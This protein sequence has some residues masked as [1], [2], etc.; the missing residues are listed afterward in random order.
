[1][2]VTTKLRAVHVHEATFVNNSRDLKEA[3][4]LLRAGLADE[5][6]LVGMLG[7]GLPAEDSP[8][9]GARIERLPRRTRR[10][11]ANKLLALL[12]LAEARWRFVSAISRLRPDVI[13]CHSLGPLA[14]CVS[15][16]HRTGA[17]LIY[18]AHEL[19]TEQVPVK[20][21]RQIVETFQERRL[22]RHCDAVLCV[23]DS[24]ADWYGRAYGIPRPYV[25]RNVPDLRF[26]SLPE[27]SN[28]IRQELG[29]PGESLVFLY[30]GRL[31]PG[32]GVE[33]FI[34][35][36][37]RA[38]PARHIVFMGY[39]PLTDVVMAAAREGGSIHFLPAVEPKRVLD[40]TTGADVGVIGVE[41]TCLN[42]RYS[43]PNKL[44]EYLLAGVP[45]LCPDLPE[46]RRVVLENGCGWA[47]PGSDEGLLALI[48]QLGRDEIL[49]KRQQA[50]AARPLY[51]WQK[52]E[53]S[54]LAAYRSV[55]E[56]VQWAS[57]QQQE[58]GA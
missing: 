45:I 15:G 58:T 34:R 27:E 9:P 10:L 39:G 30:Q 50:R 40:Y 48:D 49:A 20:G 23:A 17:A 37:Q 43:L 47:D 4:S 14:A 16:K 28:L 22:I 56:S 5:V 2:V 12:K 33:R 19:E 7:E 6:V 38:S 54:L 29:L 53:K 8:F 55:L 44:F 41:D 36:F 57:A 21:M 24:I 51:S 25:V 3:R 26:Q 52:E 46:M 18:D 42:N 31:A 11:P 13:H 1:L 35:V 32:R